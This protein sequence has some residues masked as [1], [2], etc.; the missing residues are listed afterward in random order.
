MNSRQRIFII[1]VGLIF[2]VTCTSRYTLNIII[3]DESW[4]ESKRPLK[5]Y[6]L[7]ANEQSNMS[8]I[9]TTN[10]DY[11]LRNIY[12][13]N[14]SLRRMYR[15]YMISE[16]FYQKN[17]ADLERRC[18]D[19]FEVY[20]QQIKSEVSRIQKFGTVWRFWIR[21]ENTGNEQIKGLTLTLLYKSDTLVHHQPYQVA[22]APGETITF[23]QV[24]LDLA[25]NFPLQIKLAT[26]PEGFNQLPAAVTCL[27][28]AIESDLEYFKSQEQAELRRK[29]QEIEELALEM[30]SFPSQ[31]VEELHFRIV[32]P[33]NRLIETKLSALP[34][35]TILPERADTIRFT[36]LKSGQYMYLA[37]TDPDD[38]L[39]WHETFNLE[40]NIERHL[41][42]INRRT[43]FMRIN[44]RMLQLRPFE[45][46]DSLLLR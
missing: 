43:F 1:I 16:A 24:Y 29:K 7:S 39:Q 34:V 13:V 15:N 37:F 9:L 45:P 21:L 18:Y 3:E 25:N 36:D 40:S 8:S 28:D 14:D 44:E 23:D 33:I 38:S 22:L 2:F 27:I 20:R 17:Q 41:S 35:L 31:K 32:A 26:H 6:L 12:Q 11:L 5:V 42:P 10:Q 30:E 4:R 19:L 46:Q